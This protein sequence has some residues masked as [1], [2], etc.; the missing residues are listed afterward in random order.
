[1]DTPIIITRDNTK[2]A[3]NVYYYTTINVYNWL[4]NTMNNFTIENQRASVINSFSPK[5][6]IT[7]V[8]QPSIMTD[9]RARRGCDH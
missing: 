4:L 9:G 8:F 1:M 3:L 2:Y 7:N 6:L 5:K